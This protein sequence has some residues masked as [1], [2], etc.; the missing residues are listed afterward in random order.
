MNVE[1]IQMRNSLLAALVLA[2]VSIGWSQSAAPTPHMTAVEPASGSNGDVLTV[3]GESLG[4]GTVAAVYLTDGK[5]DVKVAITA[6]TEE[7]I[8]FRIPTDMKPGRFALMVLT[9]G[10][11]PKLIEEPVKVTVEPT[12]PK[13]SS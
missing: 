5:T 9:K 11:D 13:T 8:Q 2:L 12:A 1:G 6:Q 3:T 7:S 10:K 4:P